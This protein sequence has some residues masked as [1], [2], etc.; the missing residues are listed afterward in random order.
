M[1]RIAEPDPFG[2]ALVSGGLVASVHAIVEAPRRGLF[3][4]GIEAGV[5]VHAASTGR[6]TGA[7][8]G[9]VS[10]PHAHTGMA[11]L[12]ELDGFERNAVHGLAER[13]PVL[14]VVDGAATRRGH[15]VVSGGGRSAGGARP[16]VDR[17]RG[18][19]DPA[20]RAWR[21]TAD[22]R[23]AGLDERR[24]RRSARRWR[25]VSSGEGG[26][27]DR[28]GWRRSAG[29]A[30]ACGARCDP[31]NAEG[32]PDEDGSS[33][34]VPGTAFRARDRGTHSG[35]LGLS[36][37][38]PRVLGVAACRARSRTTAAGGR[39]HLSRSRAGGAR[40]RGWTG[41]RHEPTAGR[42]RRDGTPGGMD[43]PTGIAASA[44]RRPSPRNEPGA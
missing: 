18:P 20:S 4:V 31:K 30:G 13:R 42:A 2:T 39:G 22:E 33:G 36:T 27:R 10:S 7:S 16:V 14:I 19:G 21:R 41:D 37:S 6:S 11:R 3:D 40:W 35:V 25:R 15:G 28:G 17:R 1:A 29:V 32:R 44:M 38:P 24:E 9:R 12:G 26:R 43:R 23:L 8:S 34:R 5:D